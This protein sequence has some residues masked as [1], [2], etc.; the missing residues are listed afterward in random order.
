MEV[1]K[2]LFTKTWWTWDPRDDQ[3]FSVGYHWFNNFEG[4][5]WLVL[6]GLVFLRYMKHRNSLLEIGYTAAFITFAVTDFREAWEQSSW[7][8]WLKLVNLRALFWI[9]GN[10]MRRWYPGARVY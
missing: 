9:R 4:V 1:L 10:V 5:A 7:L 3:W 6:A 2:I 8:I